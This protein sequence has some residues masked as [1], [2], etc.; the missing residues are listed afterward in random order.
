[1]FVAVIVHSFNNEYNAI[2]WLGRIGRGIFE[3]K[4][5]YIWS[6]ITIFIIENKNISSLV[7]SEF[8]L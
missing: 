7:D 5:F 6:Q 3:V 2:F 8:E 1:M 4:T